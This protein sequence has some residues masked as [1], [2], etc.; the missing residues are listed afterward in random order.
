MLNS[1]F[2]LDFFLDLEFFGV[3]FESVEFEYFIF[4][5]F[6]SNCVSNSNE[7]SPLLLLLVSSKTR[8]TFE[9]KDSSQDII[10]KMTSVEALWNKA[11]KIVHN[12]M[13]FVKL[14]GKS[15]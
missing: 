2:F 8:D 3:A 1:N 10:E 4:N 11:R 14:T 6:S 15:S 5:S 12:H 13:Y 9:P 7:D